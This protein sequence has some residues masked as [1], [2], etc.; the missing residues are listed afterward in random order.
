M[1]TC[2]VCGED[3]GHSVSSKCTRCGARQGA[4]ESF[5]P[6][7]LAD[8]ISASGS[9]SVAT[10]GETPMLLVRK[11]AETGERFTIDRARLSIGRDPLCDIFLNDVTVSRSHAVLEYGSA[12]VTIED[13]GSLNGT[14]V[15]GVRADKAILASGDIVQIGRFQMAFIHGAGDTTP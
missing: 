9:P 14:Y 10:T 11:G 8:S 12:G 5:K 6:V 13:T 1:N 2:P 7:S 3:I 4:T 15:N